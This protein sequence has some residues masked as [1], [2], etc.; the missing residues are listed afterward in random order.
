MKLKG[1]LLSACIAGILAATQIAASAPLGVIYTVS[2]AS[3][4]SIDKNT[5]LDSDMKVSGDLVL[6]ADL[7][8]KGHTVTVSGDVIVN[9]GCLTV[10][11]GTLNVNGSVE[12]KGN[13]KFSMFNEDGR[14]NI[15]GD[16]YYHS[17]EISDFGYGI[18]SVGGNFTANR[19]TKTDDKGEIVYE[20][21][22]NGGWEH[23]VNFTGDSVHTVSFN[24][25]G[26]YNQLYKV[27]ADKESSL[28]L[29]DK[30][31]G[32]IAMSDLTFAG[33]STLS[34]FK[35]L[36]VN[37]KNITVKG[38]FTVDGGYLDLSDANIKKDDDGKEISRDNTVFN[39]EGN[40][41]VTGGTVEVDDGELNVA[42]NCYIAKNYKG[43]VG[44]G[45]F[46]MFN[47][48]GRADIGGDFYYHS[49]AISDLGYGI[50]SVGGNFTANRVI[51]NNAKGEEVQEGGFNG[52]WDHTVNF[53]GDSVHIVSFNTNGGYNQLYKVTADK[54][55]SLLLADKTTGFIAMS[56]LTFAG[57]STLSKFKDLDVNGK[58]ITVN[59]DFTVDGGYLDLSDANIKKGDDGKEIS[60]DNSVFNV[61][62]S[63]LVKGG[64]VEVDD[65]ELNVDGNCYI[66]KNY[67]GEVGEG[68]FSMFNEDG[69]ANIGGDFYYYSTAISDF[70][71]GILSVGGNF[72]ANR[73]TKTDDKGESV[74][75][76]GFNG[77][78]EHTVNFTG[79]SVHT[80]S[81]NTNGGYNQLYKVTADKESVLLLTD[82]TTGFIAMS[83]LT[84][85]DG[86]TLSKFKDL[87]VNGKKITVKGDFTV[88]GG[89]LDLSDANIKKNDDGKEI[90]RD[91][92]VFSVEGNLLV[93]GGT[94]EVD[95]GELNVA[96]NCYVAKSFKGDVGEGK[97]SMFGE[98]GRANIGGDFYYHS[99]EI[100]DL[101]YGVLSVG[102][103]L[104]ANR[105]T[106]TVDKGE[107][108]NE[109]GFNGGWSHVTEF[110]GGGDH[111][112][113]LNKPGYN[114]LHTI[115][116]DTGNSL[117]FTGDTV[118]GY[119]DI[120]SLVIDPAEL[121]SVSGMTVKAADKGEGVIK[122]FAGKTSKGTK[123][124]IV[125]EA[126]VTKP[127]RP[128][129]QGATTKTTTATTAKTTVKT[130]GGT[131]TKTSKTTVSTSNTTGGSEGETTKTEPS[132]PSGSG[133]VW[134][135][136]NFDFLNSDDYFTHGYYLISGK[137]LDVMRSKLSNT[138]YWNAIY[139]MSE[140]WG[141]SC[142]GM[143]SLV[144][145]AKNGLDIPYSEYTKNAECLFDLK[146][147]DKSDDLESLINYY[148]WLQVTDANDQRF[149]EGFLSP[150]ED[151]IKSIISQVEDG[152]IVMICFMQKGWG[153]HAVVGYG[154]SYG[155]WT[156]N[157]TDYDG[158]IE[159]W[160]PNYSQEFNEKACIYFDSKTYEWTIP[161]YNKGALGSEYGGYIDYY[162][163]AE[164]IVNESG[165]IEGT[166]AKGIKNYI[167]FIKAPEGSSVTKLKKNS[168]GSYSEAKSKEGDI[169]PY[170]R[171]RKCGE[172]EGETGYLIMD[173]SCAYKVVPKKNG[174]VSA[175]FED[176]LMTANTSKGDEIIFDPNG[177]IDVQSES[178][179]YDVT[180]VS[181]ETDKDSDMF[182]IEVSGSS[183]R[184][185]SVDM[186]LCLTKGGFVLEG[187]DL[188][189]SKALVKMS[190]G[191]SDEDITKEFSVDTSSVLISG[192]KDKV[193]VSKDSDGD[194]NFDTEVTD[195][196]E[197]VIGDANGDG[198]LNVRDA[199]YI[200]KMLAQGKSKDLPTNSDFNGDGKVNVRD[201]AAIAKHLA[202]GKG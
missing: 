190:N 137:Y 36:D 187:D 80:V 71:Y 201:A 88:D 74:Y 57:G 132:S 7:N 85:A 81:F 22:F 19:N 95:D 54:E 23:T 38:D 77:G 53:T 67:K 199:A 112:V 84:F 42:G 82:K 105:N 118:N 101:G 113:S 50:L 79:D 25:N 149:Y 60:R 15:D 70:G 162:Y 133:F 120:D 168:D 45:Q 151:D 111:K 12:V 63:L 155:N 197:A 194:G 182:A 31:T 144:T 160:D 3:M 150:D 180:M 165:Y 124:F 27:T 97:F 18:L 92:T 96:E 35:D 56:D 69:R 86:S 29:T 161:C 55:S 87:D 44:E 179:S 62:E 4:T 158:R 99:T 186:S 128:D 196:N 157:G 16:F 119:E 52:G 73:N 1:K 145:L 116:L 153:G 32:F 189:L 21:G 51:R 41:L 28:L 147:P 90:S 40:L 109:G 47:E 188:D 198:K 33:G 110:Y 172:S 14:A 129:E 58:K 75:E 195:Q 148:M 103:N 72:T 130:T 48:D 141:G 20:G 13:G 173:S 121:A 37:G 59:G 183:E 6:N 102:G 164:S 159:I 30:T 64:T 184:S 126:T 136:D 9:M 181:N 11:S 43:D 193:T 68:R 17:T 122:Y 163:G 125:D 175:S 2:A 200:A 174:E 140:D 134:G 169:V 66:A 61:E 76:G 154:V 89:Y 26:G 94:V 65:G 146:S 185:D 91:N 46:L 127:V 98:D 104:T 131:T 166:N 177:N 108:V 100:S 202:S 5:G 107:I 34:K 176:C 138:E 106:K 93:K 10:G 170:T 24:T 192:T 142:Y 139:C 135:R 123:T 8:L 115:Q 152:Q 117:E 49:T 39:V 191:N 178:G 156:W 114:Q 171:Y 143:S 78:W 83:D 167:T